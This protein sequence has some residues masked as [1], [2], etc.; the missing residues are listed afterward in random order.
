MEYVLNLVGNRECFKLKTAAVSLPREQNMARNRS[1]E[2]SVGFS[3]FIFLLEKRSTKWHLMSVCV[4][5]I[6]Y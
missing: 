1:L 4:L 6:Y 3:G 5:Y 2:L